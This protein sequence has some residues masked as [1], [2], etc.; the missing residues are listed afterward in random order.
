MDIE[1]IETLYN[2]IHF[3]SRLEARWSIFW[4]A[5]GV[6]YEYEPTKFDLGE[7]RY[8]PDFWLPEREKWVEIKGQMPIDI[9]LRKGQLLAEETHQDVVIL[10]SLFRF[11]TFACRY[12]KNYHYVELPSGV[13]ITYFWGDTGTMRHLNMQIDEFMFVFLGYKL[14]TKDLHRALMPIQL[15]FMK[16]LRYQF[17]TPLDW[18]LISM[19]TFDNII[20]EFRKTH[21]EDLDQEETAQTLGG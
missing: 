21:I 15:A 8:I 1:S 2:N 11:E 6:K 3:R 18:D 13:G 9:E 7:I 12:C 16:A 10:S 4:D 5:L 19:R 14:E 17:P 20:E